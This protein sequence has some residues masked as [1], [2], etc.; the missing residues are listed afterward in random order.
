M[1]PKVAEA[2]IQE[3][4]TQDSMGAY[5]LREEQDLDVAEVDMVPAE[6]EAA[7]AGGA[8]KTRRVYRL[9]LAAMT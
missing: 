9:F 7:A 2:C 6:V 5:S 3:P 1:E 4:C 8:V